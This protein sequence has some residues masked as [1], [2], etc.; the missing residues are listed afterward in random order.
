MINIA[1]HSLIIAIIAICLC[2]CTNHDY[3]NRHFENGV[4]ERVERSY[5][6]AKFKVLVRERGRD[7]S[8]IFYYYFYTNDTL[9]VG[10]TVYIGKK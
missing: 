8:N 5:A 7:A 9:Q 6:Y 3:C 10:D 2:S 4:V 1:K